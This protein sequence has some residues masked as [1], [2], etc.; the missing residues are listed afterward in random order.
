[1]I[2]RRAD[3]EGMDVNADKLFEAMERIWGHNGRYRNQ[4]YQKR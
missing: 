1:M 2:D 4:E 3:I